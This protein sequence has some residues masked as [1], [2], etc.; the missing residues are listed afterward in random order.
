MYTRGKKIKKTTLNDKRI[1]G[2]LIEK[3]QII[4]KHC[5]RRTGLVP[6]KWLRLT[7]QN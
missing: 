1:L 6:F 7:A 2:R 3:D 4:H 5:G